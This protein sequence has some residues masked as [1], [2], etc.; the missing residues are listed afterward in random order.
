VNV[1]ITVHCGDVSLEIV[2]D[3]GSLGIKETPSESEIFDM[4]AP[5]LKS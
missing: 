1:P 2:L 5:A 4:F 3:G